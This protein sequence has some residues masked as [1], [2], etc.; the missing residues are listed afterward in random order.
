M[1]IIRT[2]IFS[3][4]NYQF[5]QESTSEIVL[6]KYLNSNRKF[7]IIIFLLLLYS[8]LF[9]VYKLMFTDNLF[10][11]NT[12]KYFIPNTY[13]IAFVFGTRPEAIKLFPLIKELRK[14]KRFICIT[15]II[16][17]SDKF[18]SYL[19]LYIIYIYYQLTWK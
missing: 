13:R 15:I 14:N 8:S 6:E 18:W 3:S 10:Y 4:N 5:L 2:S 9:F 7:K 17:I 16:K 1:K 19:F 12:K 11:L